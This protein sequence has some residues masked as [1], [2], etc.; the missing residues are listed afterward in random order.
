MLSLEIL[1]AVLV[2][3]HPQHFTH[4]VNPWSSFCYDIW[5]ARSRGLDPQAA[6]KAAF[7]ELDPIYKRQFLHALKNLPE[8]MQLPGLTRKQKEVLMVLRT[9]EVASLAQLS[10]AL[11][12]DRGNTH[13]L[14]E[15][16]VKKGFALKFFR[17]DGAYYYALPEPMP[18][19]IKSSVHQMLASLLK[20]SSPAA[21]F[22]DPPATPANARR[23]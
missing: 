23:R 10:C 16:L 3:L 19:A 13:R 14:L 1:Y 22:D 7:H 4:L 12:R 17:K 9:S 11:V 2:G 8:V 15:H 18:K 21:L 5:N 6:L 20:S